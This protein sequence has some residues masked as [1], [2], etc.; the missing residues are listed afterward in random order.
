MH[1][2]LRLDNVS[3]RRTPA[4]PVLG[5]ECIEPAVLTSTSSASQDASPPQRR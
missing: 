2:W 5:T 1:Q 4:G 3:L